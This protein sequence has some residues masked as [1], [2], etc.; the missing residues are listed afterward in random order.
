MPSVDRNPILNTVMCAALILGAI[1][2]GSVLAGNARASSV[3]KCVGA[4]GSVAFQA[5]PC[6]SGQRQTD[7]MLAS[8]PPVEP[9]PV[10]ALD[11]PMRA[12]AAPSRRSVARK[13]PMSWECRAADGQVFYRHKR[14]PA[15]VPTDGHG[16]SRRGQPFAQRGNRVRVNVNQVQLPREEACRHIHSG[17]STARRGHDFDEQ[18]SSYDRNQGRDRC[19]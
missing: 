19:L 15:S 13:P 8:P 17:G 10:Y 4:D 16:E 12:R 6:A 11:P 18:V 7:I 9:S 14:C 3:I 5:T 2:A 1:V